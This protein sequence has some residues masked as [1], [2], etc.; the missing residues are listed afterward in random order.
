MTWSDVFGP[1]TDEVI[2]SKKY[3]EGHFDEDVRL[4]PTDE[5]GDFLELQNLEMAKNHLDKRYL[6]INALK[7]QQ[8]KQSRAVPNL[9][10]DSLQYYYELIIYEAA[11]CA[12]A[13][14]IK[15]SITAETGA[16]HNYIKMNRVN[17][18]QVNNGKAG[19]IRERLNKE[20]VK[21]AREVNEKLVNLDVN[22]FA[23]VSPEIQD[24]KNRRR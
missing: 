1:K 14:D 23:F 10:R 22:F 6:E 4:G 24:Y 15:S 18:N 21:K 17:F 9:T 13:E 12:R 16:F 2:N 7:S 5:F 19:E 20:L 3:D 11:N 8:S